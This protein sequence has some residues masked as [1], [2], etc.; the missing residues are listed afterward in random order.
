[1]V[2]YVIL[3]ALQIKVINSSNLIFYIFFLIVK[4]SN[5]ICNNCHAACSTGKCLLAAD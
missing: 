4:D 5:N 3:H 2:T 1:M